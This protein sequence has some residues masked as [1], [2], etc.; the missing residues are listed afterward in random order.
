MAVAVACQ[1][2]PAA[3]GALVQRQRPIF[4]IQLGM[5]SIVG[6][7]RHERDKKQ[8]GHCEIRQT[9]FPASGKKVRETYHSSKMMVPVPFY[10]CPARMLL[11]NLGV[12]AYPSGSV[13]SK[14][15]NLEV[16]SMAGRTLDITKRRG[17]GIFDI[18]QWCGSKDTIG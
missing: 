2:R 10:I 12:A 1:V 6:T 16:W 9:M 3:L 15:G 17:G 11:E 18:S 4:Q 7:V 5:T 14:R 13:V 8:K